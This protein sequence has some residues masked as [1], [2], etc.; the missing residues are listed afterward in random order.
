MATK[1]KSGSSSALGTALAVMRTATDLATNASTALKVAQGIG[2]TIKTTRE[3]QQLSLSDL[4]KRAGVSKSVVSRIEAGLTSPTAVMLAKLA[5][6][7]TVSLSSLLRGDMG[8]PVHIQ[9]LAEQPIFKDPKSG[10]TRRTLSPV[11]PDALVEI[12]HNSLPPRKTT[13]HFPAHATGTQEHIV[14]LAGNVGI[15]KAAKA[16]GFDIGETDGLAESFVAVIG[17]L[18]AIYGRVRATTKIG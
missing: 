5:E 6:G 9:Q 17:G 8:P 3:L 12:V 7:M 4:A 14:V 2:S 11:S 16:A 13:G 15:E 10:L 18:M 1:S